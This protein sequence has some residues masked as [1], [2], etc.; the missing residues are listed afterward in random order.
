MAGA[1]ELI[2]D[3]RLIR[4]ASYSSPEQAR[5]LSIDPRSDL[6]SLGLGLL[7][8][9]TGQSPFAESNHRPHLPKRLDTIIDTL[10]AIDPNDRYPTAIDVKADLDRLWN[11]EPVLGAGQPP[12]GCR[13]SLTNSL[14][15]T[16]SSSAK[17]V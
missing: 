8:M 9:V 12:R 3:D 16:S 15:T 13:K 11:G 17:R 10:L 2:G 6:Y 4:T 7:E 14:A 1:D 5:G